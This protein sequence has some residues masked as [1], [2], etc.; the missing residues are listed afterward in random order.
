MEMWRY[1][2][3][4]RG[5]ELR[6]SEVSLR[7]D[8]GAEN[9]E[10]PNGLPYGQWRCQKIDDVS[11]RAQGPWLWAAPTGALGR[12]PERHGPDLCPVVTAMLNTVDTRCPLLTAPCDM[13]ITAPR[14]L[15]QSCGA[16][17]IAHHWRG[18]WEISM[19]GAQG[20]L[21]QPKIQPVRV[22]DKGWTGLR[23]QTPISVF[24]SGYFSPI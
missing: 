21:V 17:S 12:H 7:G 4:G 22:G 11:P 1:N 18:A 24:L 16:G 15:L 14:F 6:V 9:S 5:R 2:V 13:L 10:Q 20:A 8:T 19:P 23:V 3:G